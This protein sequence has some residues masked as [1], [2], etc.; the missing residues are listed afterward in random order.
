MALT[1][2]NAIL[3]AEEN[4]WTAYAAGDS[5]ALDKLPLPEFTNVEQDIW[6]RRERP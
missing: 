3:L 6:N 4:F 1:K 2:K 5:G